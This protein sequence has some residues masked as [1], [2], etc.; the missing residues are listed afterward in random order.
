[1]LIKVFSD[2][3]LEFRN[4]LFDHI[5]NPHPD[6]GITTLC[7]CGD[8]STGTA[9]RSFVEEMCKQFK[10][11]LMICGNHEY[12]YNDFEKVNV[13]WAKYEQDE[14]PDNF[15]FLYN[16]WRILDGVRF[17]GATMWTSFDKGEPMTMKAARQE[18]NDYQEIRCQ[19]QVITPHFILREHDRA[20]DFLTEKFDEKFD[21]PTVVMSH[22]SPGNEIRRRG[23]KVDNIG[24]CYFA[25]IEEM[26]GDYDCVDL[27]LHG[28]TH[29]NWDYLINNTR[30]I[31]NPYGYWGYATN[32]GFN[33]DLVLEV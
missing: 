11:V 15:H 16:D 28:H 1:M 14:A 2:L 26:V 17:L 18:M 7:L 10:H 30:V 6:D 25:D 29:Q 22:H 3:H 23:R 32:K 24:S 12:Y 33:R 9:S 27:W 31:C 20:I 21:G 4:N 19:G 8:I 13:D 5:H